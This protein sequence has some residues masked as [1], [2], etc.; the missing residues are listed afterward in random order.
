VRYVKEQVRLRGILAHRD[1]WLVWAF[2][3]RERMRQDKITDS[4]V[5]HVLTTGQIT[6]LEVKIDEIVHVE[7]RDVSGRRM[8]VVAALRDAGLTI[9]VIT[10]IPF[11][12]GARQ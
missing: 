7:G 12:K 5:R 6:W 4:D 2:H 3:A 10:V 8:R 1:H 11:W 9:K